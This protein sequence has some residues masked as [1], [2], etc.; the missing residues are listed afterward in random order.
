MSLLIIQPNLTSKEAHDWLV[1]VFIQILD[2]F[3]DLEDLAH[4]EDTTIAE[5][6]SY[7]DTDAIFE[8]A[9]KGLLE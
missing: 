8:K 1:D 7:A 2:T 4:Y 9:M 6:L 5:M 3:C